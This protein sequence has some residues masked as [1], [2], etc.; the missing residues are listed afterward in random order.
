VFRM[1]KV[2]AFLVL[3]GLGFFAGAY[4]FQ[5]YFRPQHAAP[6][7]VSEQ[8]PSRTALLRT[9]E[10]P[11]P[12]EPPPTS[13]ETML[14]T[15]AARISPAVVNVDITGEVR[16]RNPFFGD[17]RREV[18]GKGS[19]VIIS[20][21]GYVVTNNHVVRIGREVA[22]E[23]TVTLADGRRFRASVL[24]TDSQ[25][26]IALLKINARNLPA[27]TLGDSDQLRVGDWVIAVGNPFGLGNTV[28]AGIVSAINRQ[29]EDARLPSG[30]IQTDAAINQ[31][32]S[33]GALA[34]SRGRL[35]GINTAIF[36]PV[37]A[38]V[39]IGF[40]IPINRVRA[41]IREILEHGSIGQAWMG[42]SYGDINDPAL[43]QILAQEFPG[44]QFPRNGIFIGDVSPNSPAAAA[45]IQPGDVITEINQR[46]IRSTDQ[47]QE[48]IRRSRPGQ[49]I[50]LKVWREGRTFTVELTLGVRPEGL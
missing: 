20:S 12:A 38:N 11:A 19:G 35:V 44:V 50:T 6:P 13:F 2:L 22:R 10:S 40:A 9:I 28:T 7:V 3:F 45:G 30:L 26:D 43:R 14:R 47:V 24:G 42:I 4:V 34:D 15:A 21:D 23:I 37:G 5:T 33:G 16:I 41:I 46:P 29:V 27:A 18:A 49:K 31:G 25:N 17:M 32:N 8:D 1:R 48:L 36:S 39:G